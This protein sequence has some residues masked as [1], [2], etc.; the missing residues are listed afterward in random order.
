MKIKTASFIS[1]KSFLCSA[2]ETGLI[3]FRKAVLFFTLWHDCN[4][5]SALL[6]QVA[7]TTVTKWAA[8]HISPSVMHRKAWSSTEVSGCYSEEKY[9]EEVIVFLLWRQN[10]T[11]LPLDKLFSV[12]CSYVLAWIRPKFMSF[13]LNRTGWEKNQENNEGR[14]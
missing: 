10:Q 12:K 6:Y 14:L 7:V 4:C 11:F 3:Y 5:F 9:M 8:A 1:M 13:I 2:L